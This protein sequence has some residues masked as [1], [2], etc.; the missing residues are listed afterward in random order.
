MNL[1]VRLLA[2]LSAVAG[3][4]AAIKSRFF[5]AIRAPSRLFRLPSG[6][7][8][9]ALLLVLALLPDLHYDAVLLLLKN[10]LKILQFVIC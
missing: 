10:I 2:L 4:P 5:G 8:D 7:F 3:V 1:P 6:V 9:G